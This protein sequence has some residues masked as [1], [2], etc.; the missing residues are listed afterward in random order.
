M[1]FTDQRKIMF[2]KEIL[3]TPGDTWIVH[4]GAN[5]APAAMEH[6]KSGEVWDLGD[7]TDETKRFREGTKR[8]S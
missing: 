6:A 7:W 2:S 5:G 3:D 1:S 4:Y 8:M